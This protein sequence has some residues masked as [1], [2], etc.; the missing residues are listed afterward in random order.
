MI[1]PRTTRLVRVPDLRAFRDAAAALACEGSPLDA[2][3]RIVLVPS[4]AAASQ[5]LRTIENRSTAAN[6]VVALPALT[7]TGELTRRLAERLPE[8]PPLLTD[9]EREALLGVACRAAREDGAEPPFRLRPGLLAEILRFYDS[10]RRNQK[11][12]ATFERLALQALE[13]GAAIDRGAE[14]LVRQTRFLAG[15]FRHFKRLSRESGGQDEHTVRA[16]L[17]E[18]AAARPW[19][20][21]IVTVLDRARDPHGL[22][23]VDWDLLSR[24]PLLERLDVLVT[25]RAL[26]GAFH[27][28]IH[29][30][31]PGI[32]ETRLEQPAGPSPMLLIPAVTG[33][34]HLA[35]DREEEIGSFARWVKGSAR[36]GAVADVERIALVVRQ[37][38]PYVY[39]AREVL[40]SA[41][42]P[43]QMFD[44][45]P[46]AAEPYS[47][48]VDLLFSCIS[49]G[50]GRTPAMALLR[51][52]HFRFDGETPDPRDLAALDRA[53]AEAGYLGD[54]D[55]LARILAGWR[56]KAPERGGL[57]RALR[58][59]AVLERIAAELRPLRDPAPAAE[60]L[61]TVLAFLGTHEHLPGPDDPLRA[62]Q[63]RARAAVL[64]ILASLRDAYRRFDA[65]PVDFEQIA[66]MVRRWIDGETFSPRTGD[67]G[68]HLVDADSAR[69]GDFDQV[70]LAGLVD[71]E[72]P[73]RTP[74]SIFYSTGILRDLGWTSEADRLDG[75]RAAFADLLRL[76]S[77]ELRVSAFTLEN[78]AIVPASTML[79]EV[80]SAGLEA[81]V[82]AAD[83]TP[84]FEYEALAAGPV[85][86]RD[87]DERYRGR[88]DGYPAVAFSLSALERYQ[89]CPFKFFAADIL[90]L[91][92][93]PEDEPS[94]SPRARGRFIHEVF[95]R[96]FEAWGNRALVP[97][98]LDE[99]RRLFADVAEPL[100]G[101]LPE[102]E[103]GLERAR[104][105]GSAISIGMVDVVLGLEASRPVAVRERWLERRFEGEFALGGD[106]KVALKGVADRIDL[107]DG[108][109]LRI[110]DYKSGYAP[111]VKRAL[112]VP[113]YALCA[114]EAAVQRDGRAWSI[115][116][117]AYV[118][119]SGKRTLV[120]VIKPGAA[121]AEATLGAA[122]ERLY[123]VLAGVEAG[124][125]PPRPHEERICT[126]CAYASV[127]RKDY[128]GDE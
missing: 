32:A 59:G 34:A 94:L 66:A 106:R 18:R 79:D 119:F 113:I 41:G 33:T 22:W 109:R 40:R 112:Q 45:L 4:R 51:S 111:E 48:A 125:F 61:T 85:D 15:A 122:R 38:L 91:E 14:R 56:A 117:A 84:I 44:A 118:A 90:R 67:G 89:D 102:A 127:C 12:V 75:A 62:R 27:E 71:G 88:T 76:P 42:I 36:G 58:A 23:P 97:A 123:A 83:A 115:D 54:P 116:D 25:D 92:E 17:L 24:L 110:V 9:A 49:T 86:D 11:D 6:A 7:T 47:A 65:E 126:Y 29:Q 10:L 105:F 21:V 103:A 37:P 50:F 28:R 121:N 39:V 87:G 77:R 64:A 31:L 69:F 101:V 99:A 8:P 19:R 100:L 80:E 98:S 53:L 120:P 35:R 128:V 5:L 13:P 70:Q 73:D 1:T 16:S 114:Q 3:D 57:V 60:H 43:C 74:R 124:A 78:D 46:L 63:L 95:Q 93:A 82:Q 72:W 2:A 30:L 81:V 68:V 104:L 20:H 108:D 26:A 52:P 55:V 96:F 107:L